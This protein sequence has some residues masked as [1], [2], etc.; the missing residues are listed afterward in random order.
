MTNRNTLI[1]LK[2]VSKTYG[3]LC[4]LKSTTLDIP[5]G[6]TT[7]LIGQS[8]CG[9]S[10][11]LRLIIRLITPTTGSITFEGN[12]LTEQ[13]ITTIRHR[14]GYV[15]QDGG[16]FPHLTARDNVTILARHL[17]HT[18]SDINRRLDELRELTPLPAHCLDR[19]PTQLSGGQRQR[20]ALM[21]ALFLDPDLLLLDEPLGALDPIIRSELQTDL[22]DIFLRLSKTV[23]MV[24]HDLSEAAYFAD[25][26]VLLQDGKIVQQGIFND[27]L[28]RPADPFVTRFVNA[29][30]GAISPSGATL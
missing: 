27:L 2:A 20:V 15:I 1:Q 12:P 26:I 7:V 29:Q 30:R 11:L 9:K 23:C 13:N 16:L 14:I 24:T 25:K 22:R 6:K 3:N 18:K 5:T 4:A 28:D 17:K 19:H 10:T 21:R 8:G